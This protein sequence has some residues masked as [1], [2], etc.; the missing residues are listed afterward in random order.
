MSQL[1]K[2][3]KRRNPR[4]ITQSYLENAGLYYLERY[5]STAANFRKVMRRKITR[6]ARHHENTPEQIE[7]FHAILE[8][9]IERYQSSG[10][11]NDESYA[12]SKVRS[13][14]AK[15]HSRRMIQYKLMQKGLTT[16]QIDQA[17]QKYRHDTEENAAEIERR[18]A[19]K[20]ARKKRFGPFR[21]PPDPERYKKDMAAMARAGFSY[22][23]VK[24]ILDSEIDDLEESWP[25]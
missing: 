12:F 3:K 6:S 7:E 16:D 4:K 15:G 25:I 24:K 22:E 1:P 17:M 18:A 8:H 9:I 23:T 14:R 20:Y 5:S 13:L 19:E 11:I 10:L 2:T 21:M